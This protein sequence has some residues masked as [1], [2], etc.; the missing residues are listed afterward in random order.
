M[1][2]GHARCQLYQPAELRY[3]AHGMMKRQY[4]DDIIAANASN[5]QNEIMINDVDKNPRQ[6]NDSSLTKKS[7]NDEE[8]SIRGSN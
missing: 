1:H 2:S 8:V 7:E 3:S 4:S 6:E 5:T